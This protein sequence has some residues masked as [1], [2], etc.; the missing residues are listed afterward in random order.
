MTIAM[1]MARDGMRSLAM[2]KMAGEVVAVGGGSTQD[3]R[4]DRFGV[5]RPLPMYPARGKSLRITAGPLPVSVAR[6]VYSIHSPSARL[7]AKGWGAAHN[8]CAGTWAGYV[9]AVR[10]GEQQCEGMKA[11]P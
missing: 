7:F 1:A 11:N 4:F 9:R 3:A 6:G 2:L 5:G 8:G 10:G